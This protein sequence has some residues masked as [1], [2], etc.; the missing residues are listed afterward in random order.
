MTDAESAQKAM[1]RLLNYAKLLETDAAYIRS[2]STNHHIRNLLHRLVQANT[3]ITSDI[4]KHLRNSQDVKV[5]IESDTLNSI[6]AICERLFMFAPE[7]VAEIEDKI[8]ILFQQATT[9]TVDDGTQPTV[10]D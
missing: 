2:L 7:T 5:Q 10:I 9:P 6:G 1:F 8:E 3:S 4:L